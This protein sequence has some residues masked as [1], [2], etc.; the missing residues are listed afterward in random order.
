MFAYILPVGRYILH[1]IKLTNLKCNIWWVLILC[2]P[3]PHQKTKFY[4]NPRKYVLFG[5]KIC[6]N[7]V[8]CSWDSSMLLR[9]AVVMFCFGF[10]NWWVVV[11]LMNILVCSSIFLFIDSWAVNNFWP[12]WVELLCV[13]L[14]RSFVDLFHFC[15]ENT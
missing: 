5:V 9:I 7:L 11:H 8:W 15:C 2:N 14:H 12:L 13:F 3:N 4:G 10:L 6:F 1:K